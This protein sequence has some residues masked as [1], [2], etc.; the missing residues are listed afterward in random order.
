MS[1]LAGPYARRAGRVECIVSASDYGRRWV[2]LTGAGEV[3]APGSLPVIT[4]GDSVNWDGIW[5]VAAEAARILTDDA[6]GR[7]TPSWAVERGVT[8]VVACDG[9]G[10][11]PFIIMWGRIRVGQDLSGFYSVGRTGDRPGMLCEACW[12]AA[13]SGTAPG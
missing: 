11:V 7:T 2:L 12:N 6:S 3:M 5:R 13:T 8:D 1:A 10:L 4:G 9:C